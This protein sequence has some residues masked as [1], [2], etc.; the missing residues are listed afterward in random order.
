MKKQF[1]VNVNIDGKAA[2]KAVEGIDKHIAEPLDNLVRPSSEVIGETTAEICKGFMSKK[3]LNSLIKSMAREKAA[4][5][6][7]EELDKK[8][9]MIPYDLL[10]E[11][12]LHVLMQAFEDADACLTEEELSDMFANLITGA[13]RADY[14]DIIHP[15][16][17]TIIKQMNSND[18]KILKI[19][20]QKNNQS[21]SDFYYYF[22]YLNKDNDLKME[23][24]TIEVS[25]NNLVRL[26]LIS[27]NYNLDYS[28]FQRI[29]NEEYA[30]AERFPYSSYIPHEKIEPTVESY[31]LSQ[32]GQNFLCVCCPDVSA[33]PQPI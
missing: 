14:K 18:A 15:S 10:V 30:H 33:Q 1:G 17:S 26:G 20:K 8:Y 31:S 16:F 23:Y 11:P 32:F 22:N 4:L 12:D 27:P 5:R 3:K 6:F 7:K 19:F 2:E 28:I 25:I 13:I 21:I 24:T 9:K 29:Q